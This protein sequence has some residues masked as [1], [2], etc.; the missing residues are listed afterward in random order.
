MSLR[1]SRWLLLLLLV[2]T[3]PVWAQV[4]APRAVWV[5][6]EDTGAM[7]ESPQVADEALAFLQ[8]KRIGTMYL[9]ADAYQGRNLLVQ[10]PARYHT[11]I[12]AAHARGIRVYALL[13]SW[14]LHTERYVLP[15]YRQRAVAMLQRVLDYNQ[16]APD[17]ARFDGVNYDIEPHV[18]DRWNDRSRE[19]LLRGFLD[20]TAAMVAARDRSG[21]RLPIGPAMPFWWDGITLDWRGVRGPVSAHVIAMTDYV[22]LMDY[23]NRAAGR[24]S[25]LS[26]AEDELAQ[27]KAAGKTLLIGLDF[28]PGEPAKLSFYGMDEAAFEH[29][30]A[31]VEAALHG[32]PAFA[33]FVFHHYAGYR[34]FVGEP[35]PE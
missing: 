35:V 25:I 1:T 9:Y 15:W 28:N 26:H 29:E 31:Q 6:E 19:R 13:G 21:Q 24:D 27:A 2:C 30:A 4:P 20:M 11:L 10:Q 8:R 7:L 18:L 14:H 5:W 12:R 33:G 23:R 22:A 32:H 17:D 34:R 3:W 16:A